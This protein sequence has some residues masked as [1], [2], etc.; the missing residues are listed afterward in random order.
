MTA[1]IR[2]YSA[3]LTL[4]GPADAALSAYASVFCKAV[5]T[6]YAATER[7]TRAKVELTKAER[8]A[9]TNALVGLTSR[10]TNSVLTE[11]DGKR[12]AIIALYK[13]H[14]A[15][16]RAKVKRVGGQLKRG[17]EKLAA[18]KDGKQKQLGPK[19]LR[20]TRAQVFR[21]Q[22]KLVSLQA[23]LADL[24]SRMH[25]GSTS[26]T[27]GTEKLLR[28]RAG[29]EDKALAQWRAEWDL[30]RNSQ[31]LVVGSKD[32]TAGCQG[33]VA[34]AQSDGSFNL[35]VRLPDALGGGYA[36]LE[37]VRFH[38]GADRLRYALRQAGVR[39]LAVKAQTAASR[40][41]LAEGE[42]PAKTS[43][44]EIVGGTA[45]TWRF[46]HQDDGRWAIS[47][48]TDAETAPL[49][50]STAGGTIG[51]DINAGFISVAETDASGNILYSYDIVVPEAGLT[52]GE[53]AAAR[54]E[55]VKKV[56]A[57]CVCTKKTLVLEDLDFTVKNRSLSTFSPVRARK[58][59]SLSYRALHELFSAR[60][61]DAGVEVMTVNPAYTSV[62]G[63]VRYANR[64]GW[65][66][67]QAAAGVIGRRGQ[68]MSEKAPVSGTQRVLV[69]G[70]AVEWTIPVEIVR[71]DVPRRW[72]L[73]AR[74]LQQAITTH[75][76]GLHRARQPKGCTSGLSVHRLS[77]ARFPC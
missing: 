46:M 5:R 40:K 17:A 21:A 22:T 30:S 73:L 65:S 25:I 7:S 20:K 64:R 62:Q 3:R 68:G 56:I 71:S 63:Q 10:Q 11:A 59:S 35:R 36:H 33:C 54:G 61:L 13:G 60:A 27:F 6:E 1:D 51:V 55:A 58:L 39:A 8:K 72:P 26:L 29:L 52:K 41:D 70:V 44:K 28:Q 2:T 76:C 69:R 12:V 67:H 19:L 38:Y 15:D 31:F 4:P 53:R 32:G 37:G 77:G 49:Q 14:L 42:K 47:F 74:Q 18:H 23:G 34:T 57:L 75:Y 45:I 66:V 24:S 50:T 43:Q 9:S 16:L 48:T